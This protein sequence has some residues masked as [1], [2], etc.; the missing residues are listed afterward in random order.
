M[1][2]TKVVIFTIFKP[3]P[4]FYGFTVFSEVHGFASVN[5]AVIEGSDY[6]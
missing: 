2:R 3:F 5:I 1:F 6:A 4:S